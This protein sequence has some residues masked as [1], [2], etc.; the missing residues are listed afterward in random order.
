MFVDGCHGNDEV[1]TCIFSSSA[2]YCKL[3]KGKVKVS[4]AVS[5]CVVVMETNQVPRG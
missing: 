3:E 4:E 5:C 1:H 2:I